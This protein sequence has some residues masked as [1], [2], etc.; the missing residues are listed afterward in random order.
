MNPEPT[1]ASASISESDGRAGRAIGLLIAIVVAAFSF[2][3]IVD[4]IDGG[5]S[6]AWYPSSLADWLNGSLI[7]I[8]AGIVY[9]IATR[10]YSRLWRDGAMTRIIAWEHDEQ[11]F[12]IVM[13]V[14][15]LLT[16]GAVAKLVFEFRPLL[17]DEIVQLLQARIFSEGRLARPVFEYPEFFSTLHVIDTGTRYFSQFPA[18]GPA[19]YLPGWMFGA[20]WL[21]NPVCGAISV[22]AFTMWLRRVEQRPAVRLGAA[23]LFAVA[24]FM[25][26]MSASHMNHVPTL[27]WGVLAMLGLST[28]VDSTSARPAIAFGM[29]LALGAVAT[30]RPVDG[31]AFALPA[32]IWMLARSVRTRRIQEL[33]A[34]GA[35]VAI[36]VALLLWINTRTTGSAL[37]FGYEMLWGASHAIGFHVAPWGMSHTP[38]RGV[39]LINLYLLRL[40]NYLFE[41]P[42]PSLVPMIGTLAL[43]RRWTAWDRYLLASGGLVV[44][45]YFAYWHDGF[46]L[47]PRFM[48]TLL[49]AFALMTARFPALVRERW[50]SGIA[51]RTLWAAIVVSIVIAVSV[52]IPLR[53]RQYAN[54]LLTMRWD[55]DAAARRAGVRDA[56]VLVR[57]SWGA[58]LM[59]RLWA[60]GISRSESERLYRGIDACQL[61]SAL[62]HMERERVGGDRALP[63]LVSMLRDSARVQ[64]SPF[65]PDT[66]EGFRRGV[67]YTEKCLARIN[68]DRAGFT[69]MAPLVLARQ[70]DVLYV[71]DLHAR[72]T[73]IL[74]K[75]PTRAVFLLRPTTAEEGAPPAFTRLNRDSLYRAWRTPR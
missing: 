37:L 73:L 26:F 74:E 63:G 13:A 46:Y 27:M 42:V 12:A 38:A 45:L 70:P 36:P 68:E 32:G 15:S 41:T 1:T 11:R 5:R 59:A 51:Y 55:A 17:I 10:R 43:T 18:G 49:P 9:A 65:S 29:G 31:L 57:E 30:I 20:P 24:P 14:L 54:G 28:V 56:V 4:W 50:G 33:L 16:Y 66:T 8:G 6:A 61:D 21:T 7:A 75:Y 62:S 60:S 19:M 53:A 71:R 40:Q 25:V 2:L 39:E 58:Q 52:S 64:S 48:L 23:V 22:A 3:P 34:S 69:V 47:G 67:R 72:D 44:C 35:G